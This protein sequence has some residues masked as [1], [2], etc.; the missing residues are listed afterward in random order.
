MRV[1]KV[2]RVQLRDLGQVAP[3]NGTARQ[4]ET[5]GEKWPNWSTR[6]LEKGGPVTLVW[7]SGSADVRPP[8][9]KCATDWEDH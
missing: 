9:E 6:P 2:V 5:L 8:Y 4:H 3:G 7:T 1:L